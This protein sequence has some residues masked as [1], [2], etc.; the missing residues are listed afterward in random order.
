[1]RWTKTNMEKF[2]NDANHTHSGAGDAFLRTLDAAGW[3]SKYFI[4]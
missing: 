2:K 4:S 3:T 1:M